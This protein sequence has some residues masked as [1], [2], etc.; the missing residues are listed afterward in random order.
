MFLISSKFIPFFS[1]L[2]SNLAHR[3]ASFTK[4]FHFLHTLKLIFLNF[5]IIEKFFD[6]KILQYFSKNIDKLPGNLESLFHAK[7]LKY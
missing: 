3:D 1:S 6:K 5:L 2:K 4:E 7:Q